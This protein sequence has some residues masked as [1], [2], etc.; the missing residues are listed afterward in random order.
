MED[1]GPALEPQVVEF[2]EQHVGSLL[3]WDIVVFFHRNPAEVLDVE[4]LASRLGRTAVELE[5]EIEALCEA[6]V[7]QS[8]GGLVR[9]RPTPSV[10]EVVSAFVEACRDRGSRLAL[11]ALVLQKVSP[12]LQN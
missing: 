10:S 2:V 7:L 8:A 4:S 3:A 9:Y 5:P 12:H 6:G 11:I 1:I